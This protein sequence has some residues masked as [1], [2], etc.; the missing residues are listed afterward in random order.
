MFYQD[1]KDFTI[2]LLSD[3]NDLSEIIFNAKNSGAIILGGGIA[4]HHTIWWNQFKGGLDY[5]VYITTALEFD[6]S[7]SGA[8]TT[9]AISWGKIKEKANEETIDGDIT[10]YLP[11]IISALF[12]RLNI[13]LDKK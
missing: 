7:L 11:L 3:E 2:D 6:G 12:E 13:N 9:E 5:L 10:V 8:R 4:K 1:H